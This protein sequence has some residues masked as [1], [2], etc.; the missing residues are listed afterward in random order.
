MKKIVDFD[1]VDIIPFSCG[2]IF[3]KKEMLGE[4]K[5]RVSF[6]GL[7]V[8]KMK[9]TPVTRS[10]YL[11]N[12]FGNGYKKI[13]DEIGDYLS[14]DADSFAGNN[15]VLVYPS[16]ETG[17]FDYSGKTVWTGDLM[18]H[19]HPVQ[20]VA[21]DGNQIWCTVPEQNA[22]I[23]YSIA[24][25]KFYMRIGGETSTA[26]DCPVSVTKYEN[27]LFVCNMGSCKIRTVD[28]KNF[29]VHDF[30]TFDEPVLRYIRTCGKEI[31]HLDSGIYIL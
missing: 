14:C 25:K 9:N 23:S 30:R 22:I 1:I 28:L 6:Y 29:S 17:V 19:G 3:S 21:S 13:V 7:D 15:T 5:C 2:I 18:Y 12:K 8:Q 27:E 4:D 10:V 11:L 20:G 24:H 16:G 31:V 26:F